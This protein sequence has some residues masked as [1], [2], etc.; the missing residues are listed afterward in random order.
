MPDYR[1]EQKLLAKG[2]QSFELREDDDHVRVTT[3][4]GGSLNE[5]K[6][7]IEILSPE[8]SRF[9]RL[10][11]Q[12][13]VGAVIFGCSAAAFVIPTVK[14]GEW[15]YLW[16]GFF[17]LLPAIACAYKCKV[18]S[19]ASSI[20]YS[21]AN[22]EAVLVLWEANPTKAS[23]DEFCRALNERVRK[24]EVKFSSRHGMSAADELRKLGELRKDG[25]LSEAEF[26]AAK[27]K[28]LD[29]FENR[30]IGFKPN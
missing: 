27:A 5:Y 24:M 30:N 29:S 17:L 25:I 2:R 22:G 14:T 15:G 28:I 3:R 13:L 20:F 4:R 11:V 26:A 12:M 9:K 21:K 23:F 19:Q 18:Q 1:L 6:V 8:P 10:D 16:V 7:P